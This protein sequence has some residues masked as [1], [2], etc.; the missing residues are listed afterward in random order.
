MIFAGWRYPDNGVFN[1][2]DEVF[3]LRCADGFSTF[4]GGTERWGYDL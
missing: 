1:H 3:A 2:F 4:E